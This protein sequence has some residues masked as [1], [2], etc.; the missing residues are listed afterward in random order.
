MGCAACRCICCRASELLSWR[1]IERR[2]K[3]LAAQYPHC[4]FLAADGVSYHGQAVSGGKK[5]GAGPLALKRELREVIA[6]WTDQ[7]ELKL[8]A[9]QAE[10]TQLEADIATLDE[11]LEHLRSQQQAQEK[12]VL[13][14]DHESRKLAEN[15]AGADAA[16]S[17]RVGTGAACPDRVRARRE[18]GTRSR[19]AG[20]SGTD[21]RRTGAGA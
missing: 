21:A 10:L 18:R 12:D 5:T 13:A 17:V 15:A 2:R 4:W 9:A 11:Q 6:R 3:H 14:L 1:R 7:A 19:S 8:P 16:V 20:A